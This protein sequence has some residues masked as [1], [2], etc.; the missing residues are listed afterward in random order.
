MVLKMKSGEM[1]KQEFKK[2]SKDQ[3]FV[4]SV[5]RYWPVKE[6]VQK[7]I[8]MMFTVENELTEYSC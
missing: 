1:C 4:T 8:C 7:M 6:N 3:L 2:L 5:K